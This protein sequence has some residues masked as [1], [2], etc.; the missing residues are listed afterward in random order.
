M[1][2]REHR[3][4]EF[5]EGPP[6]PGRSLQVLC[7][8]HNGTYVLPYPCQWRADAWHNAVSSEAIE[9]KVLGWREVP[10]SRNRAVK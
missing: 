5:N 10:P 2:T 4:S 8:D 6:P 7:E 9:A 1:A 3:L